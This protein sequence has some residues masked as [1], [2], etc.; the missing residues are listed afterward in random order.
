MRVMYLLDNHMQ[1]RVREGGWVDD[2]EKKKK[3]KKPKYVPQI[4]HS[5]NQFHLVHL[6]W[7]P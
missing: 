2:L 1:K 5:S 6:P 4:G 3:K 7:K